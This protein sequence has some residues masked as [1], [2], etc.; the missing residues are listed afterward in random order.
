MGFPSFGVTLLRHRQGHAQGQGGL[1]GLD[2]SSITITNTDLRIHEMSK[3]A[4][5]LG[6][7]Y[8]HRRR[9]KDTSGFHPLLMGWSSVVAS[10]M[11][12]IRATLFLLLPFL[13]HERQERSVSLLLLP[14]PSPP[15]HSFLVH[16]LKPRATFC[17]PIEVP[18][19]RIT[20][21]D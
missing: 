6:H 14:L 2:F 19:G 21:K 15:L 7:T 12:Y 11:S 5:Y 17:L 18:C 8:T 13:S 1:V 16:L 20:E 3:Y 9:R 10:F 4:M